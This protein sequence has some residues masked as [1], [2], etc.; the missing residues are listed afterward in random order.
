MATSDNVN[1]FPS[2]LD[3][4][5]DVPSQQQILIASILV[6]CRIRGVVAIRVVFRTVRLPG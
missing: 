2:A 4:P 5:P 6:A 3:L 1:S